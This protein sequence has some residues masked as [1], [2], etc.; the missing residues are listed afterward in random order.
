VLDGINK[1]G[2]DKRGKIPTLIEERKGLSE[3]K[4]EY[5]GQIKEVQKRI[6]E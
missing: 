3:K 6:K 5:V 2:D 1:N 4:K